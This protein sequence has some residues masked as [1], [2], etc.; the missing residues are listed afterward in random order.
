MKKITLTPSIIAILL[1]SLF[2]CSEDFLERPAQG[3]LDA[4]TLANQTGV[5]ANLISA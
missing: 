5:E 4:T 2:A 1:I 3:N